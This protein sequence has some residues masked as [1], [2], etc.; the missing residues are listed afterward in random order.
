MAS[1]PMGATMP[2]TVLPNFNPLDG[3]WDSGIVAEVAGTA[4]IAVRVET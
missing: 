2:P 1:M 4:L 3:G